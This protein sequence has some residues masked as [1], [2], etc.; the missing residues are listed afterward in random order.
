LY[1]VEVYHTDLVISQNSIEIGRITNSAVTDIA[2]ENGTT[3]ITLAAI[4]GIVPV[5][6]TTNVAL[7]KS[8]SVKNDVNASTAYY[9]VDGN[10]GPVADRWLSGTSYPEYLIIDLDGEYTVNGFKTY[11]GSGTAYGSA[12]TNITLQVWQDND[13]FTV[14]QAT[15]NSDGRY[16]ASFTPVTTT[17]VKLISGSTQ[18]KLYEIEVYGYLP[19]SA[20]LFNVYKNDGTKSTYTLGEIQNVAFS[21]SSSILNRKDG[22]TETI[23][24]ADLKFI[25][26]KDYPIAFVINADK[27]R[28]KAEYEG[29]LYNDIIIKSTDTE[30]GQLDLDGETLTVNGKLILQ[31]TLPSTQ[32]WFTFGFPTT[33]ASI[34]C[35]IYPDDPIVRPY[36]PDGYPGLSYT[37]YYGDFWLKSYTYDGSG[38]SPFHDTQ[39]IKADTGYI[40]QF[41]DDFK[42][43]VI[44]F[45]SADASLVLSATPVTPTSE[46][47]LVAN[48][49]LKDVVLSSPDGDTYYHYYTMNG[50]E[51]KLLENGT[52]ATVKPFEAYIA[53]DI[54]GTPD[55]TLRTSFIID[56]ATGILHPSDEIYDPV[57]SERYYNLQGI[58]VETLRRPGIYIVKQTLQSGAEKTVKKLINK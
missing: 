33:P 39:E 36:N 29:D 45:T 13:W 1:E 15:G 22:S 55:Q 48:H 10:I 47:K 11:S 19:P 21:S 4:D 53:V 27:T 9:A 54:A 3:A 46:Y 50:N 51:F 16:G 42:N 38:K 7:H 12:I 52:T 17:Q 2:I 8:V 43:Q 23:D 58:P 44:T 14:D 18:I 26:Y 35:Q 34:T 49:S 57:V 20:K 30:T 37:D 31:K 32:A 24:C 28:T 40:M 6:I 25:S 41:S 56:V 5:P